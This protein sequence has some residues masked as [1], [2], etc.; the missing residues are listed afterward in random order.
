[1][2]T[3][4]GPATA[5]GSATITDNETGIGG[6]TLDDDSAGGE[7]ATA[8]ATIGGNTSTGS[9]ADAELVWTVRD[10]V[11]GATFQVAQFQVENGAA[12]GFYT[13]SEQ[14]L[15]VNRVY[16]VVAYDTNSNAD[17]GDIAFT[18]ADFVSL[19]HVIS[20]TSGDDVID[21]SYAGDPHGD[22]IDSGAG[23]GPSGN[24]DIV[25]AGTGDDTV[26][27]GA[28]DDTVTGG[29]GND[30]ITGGAGNDV[31]YGDSNGA[32]STSEN[33][34]W[35]GS[36]ADESS[37]AAGF[38]QNTGE[39][40]VSVSFASD[41][42]NNP[43][44]QVESTDSIYVGSGEPMSSSSSTYLY[45]N[46]LGATSTTTI[47]FAAAPGSNM[48]DEVQNVVFRISD[49]DAFDGNHLDVVTVN[50]YDA[51]GNP[52]TVTITPGS[53]DSLS[54]NT[55]TAG[56][57]LDS[58]N[59]L[60]GSALIEIAG[61]VAS[62]EIIYSNAEDTLTGSYT[63]THAIW[64]S[65]IH[66]DTIVPTDGDDVID[67]GAGDDF[68]D[69]EGG[70]DTLIGGVGADMLSGG[71]G[72][73]NL[74]VAQG[75]V[76]TGGDGDDVFTLAELGEAGMAGITIVGGEGG[77]TNGDTL[78]F[79][80]LV[81]LSTLTITNSNDAA[82]GLSGTVQM[83]DG[84]LVS[85]S[86]IE[87]IIC[88]TPGTRILTERGELPIQFLRQGDMVVTRDNGLQPIRWIGSSLVPGTGKFAPIAIDT[89]VLSD[90]KRPLLVSPQHRILIQDLR[91][92]LMF[93]DPEV[94]VSAAHMVDGVYVSR[95]PCPLV[96]YIHIMFDQHEIIYAE[97]AAT[98]SFHVADAGLAALSDQAREEMFDVFPHLRGDISLH[99]ATARRCLKRYEAEALL[100][101]NN[102]TRPRRATRLQATAAA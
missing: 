81:D 86:N 43:L 45:G 90:A 88:F 101:D 85:F 51:N 77:E 16:E 63:G 94:L 31:I 48:S 50:A 59:Q 25:D 97:G 3:W 27:S 58:P 89:N 65:D 39:M 55:I 44:Y 99:G 6:Q 87:N 18:Y 28:G 13:L 37:L 34:N 1:M 80:G 74:T 57:T 56:N 91:A 10:T 35:A 84:T 29:S 60:A 33:L 46:G 102:R 82:G 26:V 9:T 24:A 96:T 54:G 23:A 70:D 7:T 53:N 22:M 92:E 68:I 20:G 67:G 17:A 69:G 11:T 32:T 40:N 49:I 5:D 19:P 73:D 47:N 93:D 75:D 76:A 2:F 61:P 64:V 95:R 38:T 100:R 62:I 30:S 36:G 79:N 71:A 14:P 15:I 98:E 52:V 41:G 4:T 78:D 21:S 8:T 72:N 83:Y 42:D 66:F 12:A